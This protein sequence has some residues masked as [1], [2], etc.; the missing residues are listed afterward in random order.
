MPVWAGLDIAKDF[1]WLAVLDERGRPLFNGR[2]DNDPENI[3]QAVGNLK[4]A[5]AEHGTVVVGLDVMGGIAGLVAAMLL[6]AG[7]RCV[8]VPG[9]AVNR[10]RRATRGGENKSAPRD[11]KVIAEQTMLRAG[12]LRPVE[13]PEEIHVEIR[14]VVGHRRSLTTDATR[15]AARMRDLLVGIHPGLE[16]LIDTGTKSS[17]LLLSRYVAPAE[18][19]QAGTSRVS[20]FFQRNGVVPR[21]RTPWPTRPSPVLGASASPHR[22]SVALPSSSA[23]WPRTCCGFATVLAQLDAELEV[24]LEQHPDAALI[25]SLPGMGATLTAEFI[26]QVGDIRRFPSGDA[27]AAASGLAPVLAQSGR[28]RYSRG[29]SGGDE[30]LKRVFYQSSFCALQRDPTSRAFYDRKR[31]EG[32]RHHQALIALARRRVNVLYAIVRDRQPYRAGPPLRLVA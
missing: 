32:K 11:A 28:M 9:L 3:E 30:P 17:L 2:V 22:V 13:L 24:L 18:I 8:Y 29:P 14:L 10:A 12:E 7:L 1:H 26:A 23:N 25:C 6:D 4:A 20:A 31:S 19:R 16:K 5:E 27:L 21:P 15:R